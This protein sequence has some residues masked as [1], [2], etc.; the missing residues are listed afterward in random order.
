MVRPNT[1]NTAELAEGLVNVACGVRQARANDEVYCTCST[2][3][4]IDVARKHV[5]LDDLGAALRLALLSRLSDPDRRVVEEI[6][7]RH[8]G[9]VG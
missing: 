2:R 9:D 5:Q 6:C 1:D 7:Q 4:L 3:R 8:L